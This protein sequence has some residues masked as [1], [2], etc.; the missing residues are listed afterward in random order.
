MSMASTLISVE[1]G[2]D[3]QLVGLIMPNENAGAEGGGNKTDKD[4]EFGHVSEAVLRECIVNM[5][6]IKE[7]IALALEH[8]GEAQTLDQIPQLI[9]GINSGL[10]ML[11]K[12]RAV[13]IT[14][15]I[16]RAMERYARPDIILAH[17]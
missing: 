2:L 1:D 6:R 13:Q 8:P 9:N 7:A 16:S 5:A 4:V 17:S 15:H 14:E 12:T 11:G 10:L 3:S